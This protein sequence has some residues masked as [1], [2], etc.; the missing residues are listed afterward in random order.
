[1]D[2]YTFESGSI[3]QVR[4]VWDDLRAGLDQDLAAARELV[5]VK[6]PG[7]EPASG[8]VAKTQ[9]SSGEALLNS[10]AKMKA[11]VESYLTSLGDTD[12]EYRTQE[13]A[14]SETFRSGGA[15]T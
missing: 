11:F 9:N 12:Q 13:T 8:F 7:H 6:A 10:I 3:E 1:M 14:V 4:Q 5:A 15:A 2:G